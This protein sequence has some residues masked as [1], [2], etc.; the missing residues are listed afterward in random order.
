M[1]KCVKSGLHSSVLEISLWTQ[2]QGGTVEVDSNQNET[3]IENNQHYT[4]R[5]IADTLK[6]SQSITVIGENEK[7][8][9]Y[10]TEKN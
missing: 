4:T 7:C 2:L 10:F 6:I 5:D 9:F 8:V 1:I 3:L